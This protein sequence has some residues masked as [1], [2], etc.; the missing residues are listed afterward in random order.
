MSIAGDDHEHSHPDGHCACGANLDDA[1]FNVRLGLPDRVFALP[2]REH[3]PGVGMD[4]PDPSRAVFLE[5]PDLGCFV[6]ATFRLPL[7]DG[8][9]L[10][11]GL[12]I[13][14]PATV[15]QTIGRVWRTDD[16]GTLRFDGR[17]G[18]GIA[19]FGLLDAPVQVEVTTPDEL[20]RVVGSESEALQALL[21]TES[22]R[23]SVLA[24]LETAGAHAAE[25]ALEGLDAVLTTR[26]VAEGHERAIR[27]LHEYDGT[28]QFV[29]STD[30]TEE[31]AVVMH[32]SHLLEHDRSLAA[33]EDLPIGG[34]MERQFVGWRRVQFSSE[35]EMDA[36]VEG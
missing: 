12:W 28:W 9:S 35:E 8:A 30:G 2:E 27:I 32:F 34:L 22:D 7:T 31:N 5:E 3:T 4:T 26:P 19:P 1:D 23:S 36:Y 29:G 33:A 24:A 17:L 21:H 11:Y 13:R 25:G 14:V 15:A 18:N 20:P 6:R 16:Y 10:T